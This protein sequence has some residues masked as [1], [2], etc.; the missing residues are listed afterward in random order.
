MFIWSSVTVASFGLVIISIL[1]LSFVVFL[2]KYLIDHNSHIMCPGTL[3]ML[4][5]GITRAA[6]V[7]SHSG[8]FSKFNK[9]ADDRNNEVEEIEKKRKDFKDNVD[10]SPASN[11]KVNDY[12]EN[13]VPDDG[14]TNIGSEKARQDIKMDDDN[15]SYSDSDN[16]EYDVEQGDDN[17]S[18][19]NFS[20]A[21][22]NQQYD[23]P[24]RHNEIT[25][26]NIKPAEQKFEQKSSNVVQ[27][28]VKKSNSN[29]KVRGDSNE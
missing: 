3:V 4:E 9:E 18:N 22:S 28:N 1:E 27:D 2:V 5:A 10:D 19:D 8:E 21:S 14:N 11:R 26:D 6:N 15:N 25:I 7:V 16:D 12:S 17:Y 29:I 20:Q 23:S 24:A 13:P